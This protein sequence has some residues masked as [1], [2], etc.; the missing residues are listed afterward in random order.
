MPHHG[1]G[2]KKVY[3]GTFDTAVE[4]AVAYARAVAEEAPVRGRG[5]AEGASEGGGMDRSVLPKAPQLHVGAKVRAR[6]GAT[7]LGAVGTK[8]Y[9]VTAAPSDLGVDLG[10]R[11]SATSRPHLGHTSYRVR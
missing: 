1:Q 4:A 10:H 2:G 11:I 5:G 9:P 3:L 6:F 8:F 7:A